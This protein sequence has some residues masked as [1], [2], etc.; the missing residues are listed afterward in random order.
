MAG[1]ELQFLLPRPQ[2]SDD[3]SAQLLS[4]SITTCKMENASSRRVVPNV[5]LTFP[6]FLCVW[7]L[8]PANP[9]YYGS[10]LMPSNTFYKIFYA[11]LLLILTGRI[12]QKQAI[13]PSA[14]AKLL[15]SVFC[16]CNHLGTLAASP[17][18]CPSTRMS[19]LEFLYHF[20]IKC[21]KLLF[22]SQ[23]LG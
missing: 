6:G 18:S 7:D 21:I 9:H 10:F 19:R 23:L 5:L 4:C 13:L 17:E 16:V 3:R 12:H 14:E 20:T 22:L 1:L 2:E 8:G 11:E 15:R